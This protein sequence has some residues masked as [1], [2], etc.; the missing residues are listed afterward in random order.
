MRTSPILLA[1]P[2]LSAAQQFPFIDQVKS[3]FG[4]AS[5]SVSSAIPEVSVPPIPNPIAAGAAAIAAA[6][7]QRLTLDNHER[8]LRPGAATASPG[9][10]EWMIFVTGGNKTCFGNCKG[11]EQTFNASVALI[12]ASRSPP[13]LAL[14]DCETDGPLCNAWTVSIPSVLYLHIP[15]PLADQSKPSTTIRY[16]AV[17]RTSITAPEFAAL[18]LQEK[19]KETAPYDGFFHPFTGPLALAGLLIPFGYV[20]WGIARVPSWAIMIGISFF[21]RTFM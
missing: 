20:M 13:N 7:V 12:E 1:L 15:Q 2:A 6:N 9:V 18:H 4:Q 11:V 5:A 10:E 8:V 14:L 16:I 19:Y 21:S 17:N 3:L